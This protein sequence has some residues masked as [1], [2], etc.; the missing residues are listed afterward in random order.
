M[1]QYNPNA[2]FESGISFRSFLSKVFSTLAIGLAISGVVA[3]LVASNFETILYALGSSFT[4]IMLVA[5]I[6]ELVVGIMFTARLMKMSKGEAWTCYIIYSILT[7]LSLALIIQGYTSGSVVFAFIAT[8]ILFACMAI[9]GHTTRI[10]LT[11]FT[12]MFMVGLVAI[13]ITSLLNALLFKS[14]M[15]NYVITIVGVIVFLGLIA[16]D[17]QK[18]RQLYESGYMN[19]EFEEKM[20]IYGAFTLYLDFINLFIRLLQIFGRGNSSKK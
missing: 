15:V 4:I 6:A 13:L 8:V 9:I 17:M 16:Y 11:R 2:T 18:L 3:F 20:K 12:S 1:T 19:Q 10:D 7:G 14:V 5:I